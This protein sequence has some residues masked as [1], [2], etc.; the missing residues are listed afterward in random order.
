MSKQFLPKISRERF[1]GLF[2]ECL[3]QML[4]TNDRLLIRN[5]REECINSAFLAILKEKFSDFGKFKKLNY[6]L[7]YDKL[8]YADKTIA[9]KRRRP[10]ILIHVRGE[11]YANFLFL[12]AKKG[13]INKDDREKVIEVLAGGFNYTFSVALEYFPDRTYSRYWIFQAGDTFE[14]REPRTLDHPNFGEIRQMLLKG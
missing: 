1:E 5:L 6:D 13:N 11:N 7:E 3:A 10:D 8:E 4:E 2:R 12:E 9:G 14:T